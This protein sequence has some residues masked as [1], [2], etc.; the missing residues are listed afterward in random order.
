MLRV[1]MDLDEA[2][3]R[4]LE[5]IEQRPLLTQR[6][7]ATELGVSI[8]KVN[9]C[10]KALIERGHVKLGNFRR[11]PNKL[12]YR[13]LLTPSGIE[14]KAQTAIAFL[15]RKMNEYEKLRAEIDRLSIDVEAYRSA[16]NGRSH[17]R[18]CTGSE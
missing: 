13:Y 6:E 10:L 3:Y 17:R 2:H 4:L 1:A 9:N 16:G 14:A 7:A 11:N 15:Q 8:G 12:G 18:G 5:L